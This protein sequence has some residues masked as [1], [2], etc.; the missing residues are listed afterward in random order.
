VADISATSWIPVKQKTW[1]H[2]SDEILYRV[3]INPAHNLPLP[4]TTTCSP[5]D[6]TNDFSPTTTTTTTEAAPPILIDST[7]K[8]YLGC[9]LTQI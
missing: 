5:F 2:L 8:L 9:N 3:G 4:G 7:P 1:Q 6:H